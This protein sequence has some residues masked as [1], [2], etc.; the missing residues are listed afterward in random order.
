MITTNLESNPPKGK[1]FHIILDGILFKEDKEKI[2]S[3]LEKI[4]S[5]YER[6]AD[7]RIARYY[8]DKPWCEDPNQPYCSPNYY[9]EKCWI[10]NDLLIDATCLH[11]LSKN[12]PWQ[13]K[14]PHYDVYIIYYDIYLPGKL[15][16]P[17]EIIFGVSYPAITHDGQIISDIGSIIISISPL[18]RFGGSNWLDS[19]LLIATHELGHMFGAGHCSY[20]YCV[21][22]EILPYED[23][24][25][26]TMKILKD[27][28]NLYCDYDL[29]QLRR[30]LN[31]LFGRPNYTKDKDRIT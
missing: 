21:M 4:F 9:I 14:E 15:P 17:F 30:N 11:N 31:I 19:F 24:L 20:G 12:E 13:Q 18:K 8:F 28:P 29:R 6:L 23:L 1:P 7:V 22:R 27:N 10:P 16:S 2:K 26:F 5:M 3:V 25:D